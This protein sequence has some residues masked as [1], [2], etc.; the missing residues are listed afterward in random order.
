MER[1]GRANGRA[2]P[3]LEAFVIIPFNILPDA[4]HLYPKAFHIP[5]TPLKVLFVSAQLEHHEAFLS[6][7]DGRLE[8]V[9]GEV[10]LFD[11]VHGN[12]LVD[13]ILWKS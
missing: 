8:D 3:A 4:L 2:G 11:K 1:P 6:R 5:N 12:G 13:H 10:K 9:K 7:V